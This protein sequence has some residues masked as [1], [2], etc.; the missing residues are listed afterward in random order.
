M[1]E[2]KVIDKKGKPSIKFNYEKY[3]KE[4]LEELQKR[5]KSCK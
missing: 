4:K 5:N 2:R 3:L 1:S